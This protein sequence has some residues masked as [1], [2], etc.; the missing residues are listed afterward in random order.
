MGTPEI[1][2]K[3]V[4]DKLSET[5]ELLNKAK[6]EYD[7]R[8][9]DSKADKENSKNVGNSILFLCKAYDEISAIKENDLEE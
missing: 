9:D 6:I 7:K 1:I 3:Q 4:F 2:M 5:R 8:N